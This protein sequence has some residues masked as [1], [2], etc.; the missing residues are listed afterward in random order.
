MFQIRHNGV[1]IGYAASIEG[2]REI[3]RCEPPGRY[4][5]HEIRVDPFASG[6]T[7][8][9][10]G[11]LRRHPDGQIEDQPWPW[12]SVPRKASRASA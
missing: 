9:S 4:H 11:H 8:R 7:S 3:V 6:L 5:I 12:E 1:W 10:W 2:A